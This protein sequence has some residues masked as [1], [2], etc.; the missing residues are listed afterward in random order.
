MIQFIEFQKEKINKK[1]S[2][3]YCGILDPCKK[4]GLG[5]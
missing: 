1:N 5:I 2:L 4:R 3:N